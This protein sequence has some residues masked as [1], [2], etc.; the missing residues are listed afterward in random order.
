MGWL[1]TRRSRVRVPSLIMPTARDV[2]VKQRL[3][4]VKGNTGVT[5]R[6]ADLIPGERRAKRNAQIVDKWARERGARDSR[7][8][9]LTGM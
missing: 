3:V 7:C 1:G 8:D 9:F 4:T 6:L 2:K 5:S